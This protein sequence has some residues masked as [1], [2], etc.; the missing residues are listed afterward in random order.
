MLMDENM[1]DKKCM[2]QECSAFQATVKPFYDILGESYPPEDIKPTESE[3][4]SVNSYK[5]SEHESLSNYTSTGGSPYQRRISGSLWNQEQFLSFDRNDLDYKIE[6][7]SWIGDLFESQLGSGFEASLGFS[8]QLSFSSSSSSTILDGDQSSPIY[9][10]RDQSSPI[11]D[12]SLP[13]IFPESSFSVPFKV[14]TLKKSSSRVGEVN[15]KLDQWETSL[16]MPL[17][18]GF[19]DLLLKNDEENEPKIVP[20]EE[21]ENTFPSKKMDAV[22]NGSGR[23]KNV[24]RDEVD[25]DDL[26]SSKHSALHSDKVIRTE[27]F[28]EVLLCQGMN[29][30]SFSAIQK[31]VLQNGVAKSSENDGA[32]KPVQGSKGRGKKQGKKD[33]VDLRALLIYCA[34]SA[35]S[36]DSKGANEILKQIKQHASPYGDG[37]QRLAHYFAE[38]LVARLSGTGGQLYTM[39]IA[40]RFSA[41][42]I[43]KAYQLFLVSTPFRKMSHFF[44]NQTIMNAAENATALHIVDFGIL[45]GFQWP[46]LIQRL[47]NRPG[48]PPRLRI[49]GI[50]F[51]QPGFRP[52]ERIE[53]TGRRLKDYADSF[54]VPFEYKAIATKWENLNV[55]D[56]ELGGSDEV[57]IVNCMQRMRNLMD[58]TVIV[59][60]PRN[61]VLNKIRS[62]NP[63]LF[64]LGVVNGAYNAPF[65]ITRFREALFHYSSLFDAFEA[66]IPRDHPERLVLEG[67]VLGREILNV[68]ACE[69]L[70]RM[71]RPE[72]YKQWQGRTQRAG[73]VQLPL[74][75]NILSRARERVRQFYH[76]D[77]VV[78]Q[79]GQWMLMGWKGR[80]ISAI[81]TWAPAS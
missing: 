9:D 20:K 1:E 72:T 50:D 66:T 47:G 68:V 31:Q 69:G 78:D 64:I 56:L 38:S 25:L 26:P 8:S 53:E 51:P 54:G 22:V 55:E 60:S 23:I 81:T 21:L 7:N 45:Y 32:S 63:N 42:E 10:I 70:E 46:C 34:Q 28:D 30:R 41:A 58:E 14:G 16:C 65:F 33:V 37:S 40:N 48:G 75:P 76:K 52:T 27:K 77:F 59:E 36:D 3:Q 57:L 12:I 29:G 24:H 80:I 67:E 6:D 62:M 79:D 39:Q 11:Y 18:D 49:T 2:Y 35:A 4:V 44:S 5:P 17:D 13:E 61:I 71:E 43:L 73:F 15:G 74:S 19:R